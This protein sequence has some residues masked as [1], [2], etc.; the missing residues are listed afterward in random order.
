MR[1]WTE[2]QLAE[3]ANKPT[4]SKRKAEYMGFTF[5]PVSIH[6]DEA[7][8][9]DSV[10][11]RGSFVCVCGTPEQFMRR[12]H[13]GPMMPVDLVVRELDSARFLFEY[14]SF[15]Y[16]HL[17]ADGYTPEAAKAIIDKGEEFEYYKGDVPEHGMHGG[18]PAPDQNWCAFAVRGVAPGGSISQGELV[19]VGRRGVLPGRP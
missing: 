16:K 10:I 7:D 5:G 4:Y 1:R 14:G 17:I 13:V 19:G 2:E 15:S 11:M 8:F 12:I 18:R 3:I 9:F 6:P